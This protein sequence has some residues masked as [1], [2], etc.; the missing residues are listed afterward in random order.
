[1][2]GPLVGASALIRDGK[3]RVVLIKRVS[4]P[5]KGLW[6]LP[7]GLVE[8]GEG[9]RDTAI[10]EVE[11]ETGLK[12]KLLDLFGVYDVIGRDGK[13]DL[14]YHYV[15]VCFEGEPMGGELRRGKDVSDVRWFSPSELN[16]K[17]ITETTSQVLRKAKIITSP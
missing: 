17:I 15:V 7:G 6:A 5:G 14:R 4:D 2:I 16:E 9:I 10:R 12:I 11:E 8:P 1:M 13:G 3:N